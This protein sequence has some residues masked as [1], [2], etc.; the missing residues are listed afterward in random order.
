M[1]G[2]VDSVLRAL[3]ELSSA[4]AP[5]GFQSPPGRILELGPGRTPEFA[6]AFALAGAA[7]M[8]AV[9]TRL[10]ID[11]SARSGS[12]YVE[13]ADRLDAGEAHEF[14]TAMGP[15]DVSARDRLHAWCGRV[16]AR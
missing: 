8:V 16:L 3:R 4:L 14:T 12:R 6:T 2:D 13:L 5:L 10:Q 15:A 1:D 11:D 7:E 9:D